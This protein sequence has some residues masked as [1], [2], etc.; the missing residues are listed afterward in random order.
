MSNN[1]H[2]NDNYYSKDDSHLTTSV[3]IESTFSLLNLH[4]KIKDIC[5]RKIVIPTNRN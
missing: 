2:N 1:R 5:I 3:P 4:V